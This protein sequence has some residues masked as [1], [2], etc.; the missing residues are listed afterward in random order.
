V[1]TKRNLSVPGRQT[2]LENLVGRLRV[3]LARSAHG[4]E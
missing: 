4:L 3:D 2:V 1:E